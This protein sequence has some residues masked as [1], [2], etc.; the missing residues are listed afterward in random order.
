VGR[1]CIA[2]CCFLG[3]G[4]LN[5]FLAIMASLLVPI[6]PSHAHRA[7]Y[8]LHPRLQLKVGQVT[9]V[10]LPFERGERSSF[11]LHLLMG[12]WRFSAIA[13]AKKKTCPALAPPLSPREK[14]KR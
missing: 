4:S 13:T 7:I 10:F 5:R 11:L 14:K 12:D 3:V 1:A 8:K 2:V 9:S 6:I